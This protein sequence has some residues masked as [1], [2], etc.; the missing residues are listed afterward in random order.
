M[1]KSRQ[2][3]LRGAIGGRITGIVA[4]IVLI[5]LAFVIGRQFAPHT[6]HADGAATTSGGGGASST[7][8]TCSMHPQIRSPNPGQCPICFMDLIPA[9]GADDTDDDGVVRVRLG[10]TARALADV[11][12]ARVER[13]PAAATLRM[14]GRVEADESRVYDLVVLTD[15]VVERLYANWIGAPVRRGDLIA[16]FY[17]PDALTAAYELIAAMETRRTVQLGDLDLVETAKQKLRLLGVTDAD[18]DEIVRTHIVKKTFR[19]FSPRT[20]VVT[21]LGGHEGHWLDRGGD[22]MEITDFSAVWA[23]LDAYETDLPFMRV[24]QPVTLTTDAAPGR[25]YRGFVAYVPPRFD[26][27][28]RSAKVRLSVPNNDGVLRPGMFVRAVVEPRIGADGSALAPDLSGVYACP[29]H[30]EQMREAPGACDICG[31]ALE[32]LQTSTAAHGAHGVGAHASAERAEH[33]LLIPASAP[34]L[35][36]TRAV[37][38]VEQ[39]PGVYELREVRL[40]GRVADSYVVLDGLREG[41]RV[42]SRGAFKIDSSAQIAGKHSMMNPREEDPAAPRHHAPVSFLES[43]NPVYGAYF[44]AQLALAHD[45]FFGFIDAAEALRVRVE[46]ADDAALFGG[47]R[48]EWRALAQGLSASKAELEALPDID[49][50]RARFERI[51]DAAIA[52]NRAFGHPGDAPHYVAHCPMA[53]EGRRAEWLANVDEVQNPYFGASMYRCG[54][55][56]ERLPGLGGGVM[57]GAPASPRAPSPTPAQPHNH[58]GA[59]R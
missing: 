47:A 57:N 18:I 1:T 35:T 55:I 23:L 29:M 25:E 41:E 56:D 32:P 11:R 59:L 26:D 6:T 14:V 10:P 53:F 17:S 8:W 40:G 21:L 49:A 31:M 12:T 43:L 45:D 4:A 33:P 37:V 3:S 52:L 22:L 50:A 46:G 42:V 9:T 7:I 15:G 24:G 58:G 13:R 34:L 2:T 16:E 28:T 51:A 39:E 19:I 44:E 38:Y 36:G 54:V 5:V 20:G 48:E 27:A 30:P